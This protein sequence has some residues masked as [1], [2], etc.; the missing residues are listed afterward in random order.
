MKI[1][2]LD[3]IYD[4]WIQGIN[5]FYH[6][7]VNVVNNLI[8]TFVVETDYAKKLRNAN[9]AMFVCRYVDFDDNLAR[10]FLSNS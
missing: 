2:R 6:K 7:L 1:P 8:E 10:R 5:P 4:K 3:P 9:L